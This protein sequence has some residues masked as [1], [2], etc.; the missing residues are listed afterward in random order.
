[1][2]IMFPAVL[3]I[4]LGGGSIEPDQEFKVGT[5]RVGDNMAIYVS[6]NRDQRY[7]KFISLKQRWWHFK[8]PAGRIRDTVIKAEK[9]AEKLNHQEMYISHESQIGVRYES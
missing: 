3:P 5:G 8:S 2:A 1:M 7:H 6:K 4:M 9:I